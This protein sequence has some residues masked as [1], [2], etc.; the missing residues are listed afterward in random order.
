MA[1]SVKLS[2]QGQFDCVAKKLNFADG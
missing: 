1:G 2:A